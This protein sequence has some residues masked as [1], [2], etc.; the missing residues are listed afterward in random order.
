MG[1]IGIA[2]IRKIDPSLL[3]LTDKEIEDI[4]DSFYD[5]GQLMFEDWH[6]QKFGSKYPIWSLTNK[7]ERDTI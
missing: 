7:Q 2:Q 5:F 4:R 6:E 1:M 3:N